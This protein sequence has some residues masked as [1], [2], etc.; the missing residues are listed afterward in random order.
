MRLSG[1]TCD[2]GEPEL[3]SVQVG[4]DA[5]TTETGIIVRRPI[6]PRGWCLRCWARRWGD[7]LTVSEFE[8]A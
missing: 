2:C 3:V 4:A 6:E 1:I 8:T 5:E 7:L